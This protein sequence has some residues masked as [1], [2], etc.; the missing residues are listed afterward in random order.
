MSYYLWLSLAGFLVALE[1][2][3][4]TFYLIAIA[5][6]LLPIAIVMVFIPGIIL[7][8]Q[9]IGA[10]IGV[11][12]SVIATIFFKKSSPQQSKFE[13]DQGVEV[14]VTWDELGRGVA[15]YRGSSW[16]VRKEDV[17]ITNRPFMTTV[18]VEGV[19]LVVK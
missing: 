5:I 11:F 2:M 13:M 12:L 6:G 16:V 9:M 4:G 17:N 8:V 15:T 3:T 10:A 19:V 7:P 14:P 18:C 1:L